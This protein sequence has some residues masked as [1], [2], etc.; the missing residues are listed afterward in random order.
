M[1]R[2]FE[3][4]TGRRWQAALM[5]AS[6]GSVVLVFSP[7]TGDGI[8]QMLM[9]AENLAVAQEQMAGFDTARLRDLLA[10]ADPWDAENGT[11]K[12]G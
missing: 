9:P 7:L 11:M 8:R 3:D 5:D 6:Y 10:E 12:L 4:A 1:M 2:T